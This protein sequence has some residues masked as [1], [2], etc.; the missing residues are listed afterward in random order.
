MAAHRAII[1]G[2][3][4]KEESIPRRATDFA[5]RF[6]N[7][8]APLFT[9]TSGSVEE[10][11]FH[12]WGE[13]PECWKDRRAHLQE[14]FQAALSLK[15]DS[16]V[17]KSRYEFAIYPLGTTFVEDATDGKDIGRTKSGSSWI[18]ASFHIHDAMIVGNPK[19]IALVQTEN[20]VR[21]SGSRASAKYSKVLLFPKRSTELVPSIIT[22]FTDKSSP[23]CTDEVHPIK[24]LGSN[25][26]RMAMGVEHNEVGE[27][28]SNSTETDETT[29][30]EQSKTPPLPNCNK[31]GEV[32]PALA[33]L[34]RHEKN[35]ELI[36][37]AFPKHY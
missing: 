35:S 15:A 10:R 26:T 1:E 20:F 37:M 31:C 17:T 24:D 21:V 27:V 16:V 22:E 32:F 11:L 28:A 5:A 36:V 19:D 30:S 14:I 13:N 4:F 34:R 25:P 33:L 6:S 18:H 29:N 3:W 7:A 23:Q 2:K 8:V 12:T 9:N